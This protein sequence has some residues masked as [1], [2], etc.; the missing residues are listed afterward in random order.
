MTKAYAALVGISML[1]LAVAAH[2]GAPMQLSDW[3][4][5]AVTAGSANANA[6]FQPLCTG[7]SGNTE[8]RKTCRS[9]EP[10]P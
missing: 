4:V 2:A 1:G 3:Q 9:G 10:P 7:K 8:H 6:T 5:Q